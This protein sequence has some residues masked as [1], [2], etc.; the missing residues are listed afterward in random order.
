MGVTIGEVPGGTTTGVVVKKPTPKI[1]RAI[2]MQAAIRERKAQP[3]IT[4]TQMGIEED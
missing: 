3:P 1:A 2:T 4:Q